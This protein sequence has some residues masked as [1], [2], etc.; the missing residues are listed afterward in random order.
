[1]LVCALRP[2]AVRE[3]SEGWASPSECTS[4][5]CRHTVQLL[6]GV[7]AMTPANHETRGFHWTSRV[8]EFLHVPGG[9]QKDP[10]LYSIG[11]GARFE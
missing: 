4:P 3:V 10:S 8:I 2:G 6:L 11:Q 5:F 7:T 9:I 1:M